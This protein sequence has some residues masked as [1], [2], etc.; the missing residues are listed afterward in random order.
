MTGII[1]GL[2]IADYIRDPATPGPSLSASL[3]HVLLTK[4]PRHC[5]ELHPR[6]SPAWEPDESDAGQIIGTVTHALLL[7]DDR[8]RVVIVEAD[9]W[10]KKENYTKKAE[11]LAAGDLLAVWAAG[12][13]KKATDPEAEERAALLAKV[14]EKGRSRTAD[15][16]K[17]LRAQHVG[18]GVGEARASLDGLRSLRDALTGAV[19]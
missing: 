15:A 1:D 19:A 2:P 8:S 18:A 12:G 4:S 17:A 10:K 14:K 6:L 7:E 9:D 11:A 13:A 5:F 3:A 16:M